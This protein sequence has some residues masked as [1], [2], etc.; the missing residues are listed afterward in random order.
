[1]AR[2]VGAF[3]TSHGPL[4]S[5]PPD[6]WYLRAE[7]DRINADH[8]FR[9]KRYGFEQL[10]DARKPGFAAESSDAKKHEHFAACQR[11]LDALAARFAEL[12]PDVVLIFGNDQEEIFRRRLPRGVRCLRG[13]IESECLIAPETKAKLEPGLQSH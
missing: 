8:W 9:G 4:L 7:H 12:K 3:A 1:M 10:L 11:A 13:S 5:T 2:L 6:K